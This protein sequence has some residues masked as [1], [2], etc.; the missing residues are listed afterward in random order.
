MRKHSKTMAKIKLYL[1]TR[2]ADGIKKAAPLKL[3]ITHNSRTSYV[4]LNIA[5]FTRQ[6][7]EKK[8]RVNGHPQAEATCKRNLPVYVLRRIFN[9]DGLEPWMEKHRDLFKLTFMLI[10]I[11]FADL[12]SLTEV[13]E[14]RV[15]YTRAKTHKPYSIKVEPEAMELI[16]AYRGKKQLLNYLD[17]CNSYPLRVLQNCAPDDCLTHKKYVVKHVVKASTFTS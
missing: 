17:N 8:N 5:L 3:A 14:G 6:F 15:N 16:N 2:A 11:N 9:A 13:K 7:D 1:D 12:C 10:G 4:S